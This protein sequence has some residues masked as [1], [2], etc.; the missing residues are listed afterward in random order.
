MI[1]VEVYEN[2]KNLNAKLQEYLEVLIQTEELNG[3]E[4]IQTL[5]HIK[6]EIE[7]ML[8]ISAELVVV[9]KSEADLKDLKYLLT[10]TLF[11]LLD[12]INFCNHNELGRCR[13]RAINYLGK[14]KRVEVFGQ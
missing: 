3:V 7:G 2:Y 4:I 5:E 9:P 10:D 12:L 14:R 13:M 6:N 8:D 11:L 1:L